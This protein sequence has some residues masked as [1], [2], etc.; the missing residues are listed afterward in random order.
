MIRAHLEERGVTRIRV[1]LTGIRNLQ[2]AGEAEN[3]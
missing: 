3:K 2:G 1:L